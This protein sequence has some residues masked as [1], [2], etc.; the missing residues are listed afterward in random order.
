MFQL[1]IEPINRKA[2]QSKYRGIIHS[3]RTIL[4]EETWAAFWKG[5]LSS[6][7]L[8]AVFMAAEVSILLKYTN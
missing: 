7:G 4:K 5:H 3:F 2:T 1:Q 6:Q 8:A